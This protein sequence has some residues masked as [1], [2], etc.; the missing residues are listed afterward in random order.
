MYTALYA[1]DTDHN[2]QLSDSEIAAA[3]F[4]PGGPRKGGK[5]RQQAAPSS[6]QP[7]S[8]AQ[9]AAK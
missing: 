5:K 1:L 4:P 7:Q 8:Q 6:S 9:P 2:G 3:T